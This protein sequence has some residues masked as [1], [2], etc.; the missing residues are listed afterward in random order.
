MKT[1]RFVIPFLF[2]ALA[3]A[4]TSSQPAPSATIPLAEGW[5]LQSST[6][7][8]AAGE[9]ISV[10]S[11]HPDDWMN[12][13]V[14]TTVVA[15]QVKNKVF[16]DPLFGMNLRHYPGVSYPIGFNFSNIP[17]PP[18]SPY[19]VSWWYRKEFTLS[20]LAAGKTL[21]LNFRGINYRADIFLN[22]KKIADSK[23]VAGAWRTYEFNVTSAV[24]SGTN[25]VAV[26]VWPPTENSLA[27][28]FVDW[29]PAPPDK[30]MG[31]WH[32]VYLETSGPVALRNPA[33]LSKVD[34]PAN[35]SAHLTVTVLAK[36][37]TDH[38]VK[39]TL[40]GKIGNVDFDQPIELAANESKDIVFSPEQYPQLNFTSPRL[41][42]PAQMG[43][44]NLYDL[45]LSFDVDGTP[46]DISRS[47]FGIREITS[48]VS[49]EAPDRLKRLFKVNGKNILIRGG[50]WTPDMM[51]RE[52]P[53]R[54]AD[55]FRYV[56]DMGLNTVRLEG[57]LETEDFF[58]MA[59]QQ[60]ILVMAGW[61]CCDFWEHWGSW[62]DEDFDIAKA[63]LRDQMYR[64]RRH[65]SMVMWLNGS[66]NPPPPDVEET[67]LKVESD[68]RWPNPIVSSATA[69]TSNITDG[70]GV[71]MTGPYEYVAPSYWTSDPHLHGD[72][73]ACNQG[74]CGGAYGFN[75]ETSMGPAIPPIESVESMVPK[76]HLWP[77][78]EF[79]NYHAGGGAFKNMQVFTDALSARY[80]AAQ[81]A[82]DF[83]YKSQLM[84]YEG[85]RAMY[86]AYSRNKYT[87][88]GVIQWMLNNAWPS[89]IWH[90]YDYYLRPGG[91]Y[92]GAKKAMQTL[93]P[94]YGYDDHSVW[95][96]SSQY[97]DAKGLKLTARIF[98]VDGTQKFSKEVS[99]DAAADST[100]KVF[101]VPQVA[102]L[103][104]AYFL[105]LR[106]T[107]GN[108][109]LVGSNF[110]WLSTKPETI[111]WSK[112][113]WYTTP[114]ASFADYTSLSQLP[115][116]DVAEST[117]T[118]V[119]GD[120][121]I[122][123]VTL[124]NRGKNVAFFLRL[125][126]TKQGDQK[127]ILPVVWQD[128]Y[129][130]LLPGEKREISATYRAS[131]IGTNPSGHPDAAVSVKGW[132]VE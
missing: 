107:E 71:K 76:E 126:L 60:G 128:N 103:S 3:S 129:I 97:E 33:V 104:A 31:L 4:Q 18:D 93:D 15:A 88:T 62:K 61:C 9:A 37:G 45:N 122:T 53:E 66:D 83:T 14:P 39:G 114:T 36:N 41:W 91:G 63:S 92:F 24:K 101:E 100:A 13:D 64:L 130:S 17:M 50:G 59:D 112:S 131:Q 82:Q 109:K 43:I 94:V 8:T 20:D 29:N 115:K 42:W 74:G 102:G 67:Y 35:N 26:Q 90:L 11:F 119:K 79:W 117:R 2:A 80:G 21:W 40:R 27:I 25:V 78:D 12:A 48:E 123:H 110:Y 105:D 32:E 125:K 34:S 118:E 81:S 99:L 89:M 16:P 113:N 5:S 6:K 58:N 98:N 49:Q 121:A 57:K 85:V 127:E 52:N 84:T 65:P 86:E 108:G 69:K 106:V 22:G 55:E 56:R 68:L 47:K 87:S 124:V 116:A 72:D 51:M 70:S 38:A 23:D 75:T 54:L 96:V 132:N 77:V 7:V 73:K 44:P 28:T 1:L 120:E 111:D 19:A 10:A 95:L 46:S 30:N